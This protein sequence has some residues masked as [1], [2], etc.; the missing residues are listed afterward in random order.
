MSE[1]SFK[2]FP[3]PGYVRDS[4]LEKVRTMHF[5]DPRRESVVSVQSKRSVHSDHLVSS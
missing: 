2:A 1:Y 5:C 4:F 3:A